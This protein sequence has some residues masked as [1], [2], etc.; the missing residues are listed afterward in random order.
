[1]GRLNQ[2]I[3][4]KKSSTIHNNFYDYSLSIFI[5]SDKKINIICPIH[6]NFQ[7]KVNDHLLGRGCFECAKIKRILNCKKITTESF[8]QRVSIIHNNKYDYSKS[9]FI[10]LNDKLIITCL[11][12]DEFLQTPNNHLLGYGCKKCGFSKRVGTYSEKN[13]ENNKTNWVNIKATLYVFETKD[14]IKVG[15]TKNLKDRFKKFKF[16]DFNIVKI[17]DT[18]LYVA[19]ILENQLKK[20]YQND[21]FDCGYKFGGYTELYNKAIK[22]NI[23]NFLKL[24]E[25]N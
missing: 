21:K 11:T 12:H 16:L 7:Q 5:K 24:W 3:F 17:Y 25:S 18:N 23:I 9:I 2:E 22:N 13:A 1:M 4:I 6:G 14:F 10:N 15:I 8:I 19:S 20:K